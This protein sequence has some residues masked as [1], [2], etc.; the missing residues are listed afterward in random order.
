MFTS[1]GVVALSLVD[2]RMSFVL[3]SVGTLSVEQIRALSYGLW[4]V[5]LQSTGP[6]SGC[7]IRSK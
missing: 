7:G 1:D 3:L 2:V 4:S 5:C 6:F